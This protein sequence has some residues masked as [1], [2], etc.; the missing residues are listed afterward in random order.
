MKRTANLC[1]MAVPLAVLACSSS[2][3]RGTSPPIVSDDAASGMD[4]TSGGDAGSL[5]TIPL[6]ACNPAVY[7]AAMTIGGS[8][9]FQ[10][11]LDTGSTTLGVAAVGC[12]SCV[13]AGV[14]NLYQ[15]GPTAVDEHVAVDAGYGALSASG[16]SGEIYKD[17]VGTGASPRMGEVTF[18]AIAQ[19]QAFLVGTCG[20]GGPPQGVVGFAQGALALPGTNGFFDQ[21]VAGRA[22]PNVFATEL[23]TDGGTLWLGGYDQTAA[24]APPV[25]TPMV[26]LQGTGQAVYTV[27]LAAIAVLGTTIPI[28]SSSFPGTFL[29]TGASIWSVPPA[30]LSSLGSTIASSPAFTSIFGAAPTFF[31]SIDNHVTLTQTKAE[32]DAAL[33]P[34]TLTF[35]S[36]PAVSVQA[37]ATESYLVTYGGGDWYPAMTSRTP[38]N[39]TYPGIAA[40]LGPPILRSNIVIF[41]R[42]NK[43]IG[44][45]PH[46]ACP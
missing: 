10:L 12:T 39:S 26:L 11:L 6:T 13:D 8:Q 32:L 36:S 4:G 1:V 3:P 31:S 40:I 19:E 43:R 38:D 23:C 25:Y 28:A 42:A 30:A 44:F 17:W 33:P 29:D 41:D 18:G 20:P 22:V 37:V 34:L 5:V 35:G 27:N 21:V 45:A 14:S 2:E 46:A 16:W 15:P 7:S 9:T 24:T